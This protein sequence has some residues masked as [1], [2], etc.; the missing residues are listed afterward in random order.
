MQETEVKVEILKFAN[1]IAA[2]GR[3]LLKTGY[4]RHFTP[5]EPVYQVYK[6]ITL[7]WVD[8]IKC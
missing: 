7:S 1:Q 4:F 8:Y 2:A 3:D 5:L 6:F